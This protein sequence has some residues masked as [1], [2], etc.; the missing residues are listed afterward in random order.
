MLV[1]LTLG[2]AI[3]SGARRIVA[4]WFIADIVLAL[5]P[6]LYWVASGPS[7]TVLGLPLSMA[8]FLLI[9]VFISAS[10]VVAFIVERR[11]GGPS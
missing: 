1:R 8:Y 2:M 4:L 11:E 7:P 5:L 10:I 9:A 6:P 3:M